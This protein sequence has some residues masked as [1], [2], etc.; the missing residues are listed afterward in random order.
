LTS[1]LQTLKQE[2]AVFGASEYPAIGDGFGQS[3]RLRRCKMPLLGGENGHELFTNNGE[4]LE[5]RLLFAVPKSES[6]TPRQDLP[7]MKLTAQL[8]RDGY[9]NQHSI[10]SKARTFNSAVKTD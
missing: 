8:Q 4:S 10:S 5:G 9:Y 3:V 2:V 7:R 6:S 1:L